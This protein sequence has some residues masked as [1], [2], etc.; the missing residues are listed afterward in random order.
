[1]YGLFIIKNLFVAYSGSDSDLQSQYL[2]FKKFIYSITCFNALS[3][4]FPNVL[5][6]YSTSSFK[7]P[8]MSPK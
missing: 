6:I 5:C 7:T 4:L 3:Y 2:N 1:M 8:I